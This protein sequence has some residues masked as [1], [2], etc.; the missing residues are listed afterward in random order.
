MKSALLS[1]VALAALAGVQAAQ[2]EGNNTAVVI[3]RDNVASASGHQL[4]CVPVKP[5]NITGVTAEGTGLTFKLGEIFP[6]AVYEGCK[7]TLKSGTT[8]SVV[9][10]ASSERGWAQ[11][12]SQEAGFLLGPDVKA[13]EVLWLHN[14]KDAIVSRA[15]EGNEPTVFCGEENEVNG[16]IVRD[17]GMQSIGNATS[18]GVTL[19]E[20]FGTSFQENDQIS[21]IAERGHK[22]YTTYQ[23]IKGKWYCLGN[24][25]G[26]DD[27]DLSQVTI[28]PGEAMYYH[29]TAGTT[30]K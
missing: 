29:F 19:A 24:E 3:R 8:D 6:P 18:K 13:G 16:P 15:V 30:S 5:F 26:I 9:Y 1:M 11:S 22:N 10:E 4:L 2:V 25:G 17:Q 12:D 14:P 28:A 23:Y 20:L 7:I 21:R 27:A